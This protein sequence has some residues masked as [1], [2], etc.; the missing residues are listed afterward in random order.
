MKST[1]IPL[2]AVMALCVIALGAVIDPAVAATLQAYLPF[3]PTA[4]AIA[5]A[6]IGN[7]SPAGARI[8]DPILSNVAQGY[9]HADHV[10]EALCPTV[11]VDVAGGQI[12]EFGKES[13]KLY[14]ARRAPGG[15]T[16][17]VQFGYLGKPYA[18]VQDALEGQV[19]RELMRDAARVPG[20][21]LGSRSV[22]GV[23]QALSLTREYDTAQL[24]LNAAN[25]DV[26]HKVDLVA[27]KWTDNANNPHK[28][29][30]T[31]KEAVRATVGIEPNVLLL[32]AKA[33]NAAKNNT[34][35]VDRFKYTSKD[36]ITPDMLA[37]LWGVRRVVVGKAITFN[38]AGVATDIWGNNAVLAYVPENPSGMEEPSF[39]YTYVMRGHPAVEQAYF[40]NNAKSWI[41][42]VTYERVPVLSGIT[43]GYLIQNPG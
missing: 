34:L 40:D 22:N 19:P 18:L 11:P 13:F 25:Y 23:M 7:L 24:V 21:D 5:F 36:S 37:A 17:R 10:A 20:V 30:D 2:F 16:K 38:D 12:I 31:G 4:G 8:I 32:S 28:D 41:Y 15:S 33:F 14:N 1:R 43:S 42:P 3:D 26:A 9:R 35:V 29:I 27:A 39:G 6:G